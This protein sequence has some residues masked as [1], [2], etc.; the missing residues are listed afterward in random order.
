MMLAALFLLLTPLCDV[1]AASA[2]SHAAAATAH[3]HAGKASCCA[4]IDAQA[5]AAPAA[6]PLPAAF[7]SYLF[8]PSREA[9][10]VPPAFATLSRIM[11]RRDPAP[12]LPYHARSLRRL[13]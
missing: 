5:L 1:V 11:V 4:S 2:G 13:D 12:P 10:I 9:Q 7:P 3:G 6:V 8:A